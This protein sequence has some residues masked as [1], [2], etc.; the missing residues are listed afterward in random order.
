MENLLS[1][2][3]VVAAAVISWIGYSMTGWLYRRSQREEACDED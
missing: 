1:A 3:I 2:L